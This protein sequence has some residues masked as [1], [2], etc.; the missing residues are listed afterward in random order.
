MTHI[1]IGWV[2]RKDDQGVQ[3][4]FVARKVKYGGKTIIQGIFRDLTEHRKPDSAVPRSS[5]F[6][7]KFF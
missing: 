6:P 7:A 3:V 1:T 5:V 4:N 2:I